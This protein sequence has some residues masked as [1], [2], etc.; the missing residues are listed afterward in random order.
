MT[1]HEQ[2]LMNNLVVNKKWTSYCFIERFQ[3]PF[4]LL[5]KDQVAIIVQNQEH[6]LHKLF[7]DN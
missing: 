2:F 1:H 6:V 5:K 3:N 4:K 7:H